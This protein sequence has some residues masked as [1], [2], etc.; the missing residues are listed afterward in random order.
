MQSCKCYFFSNATDFGEHIVTSH[1]VPFDG[2]TDVLQVCCV[3]SARITSPSR[4]ANSCFGC[5]WM[6]KYIDM[7]VSIIF[8]HLTQAFTLC[9]HWVV[10]F[11]RHTLNTCTQH[12]HTV[13]TPTHMTRMWV[14]THTNTQDSQIYNKNTQIHNTYT[15][16]HNTHT[17]I[18]NTYTQKCTTNT[19][20]LKITETMR[21]ES[22][23][24]L[25][26]Y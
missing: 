13:H 24:M 14:N 19:Q 18:H 4:C 2:L 6:T 26:K 5:K 1:I 17:Q 20:R 15:Q 22:I 9:C 11:E 8:L 7:S 3:I 16:I 23:L 10:R 25:E 12:I 21:K